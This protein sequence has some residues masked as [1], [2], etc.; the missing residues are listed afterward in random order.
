MVSLDLATLFFV[1][2]IFRSL[3]KNRC[4]SIVRSNSSMEK[5]TET[6]KLRKIYTM[7]Y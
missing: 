4:V 7:K 5:Q 3:K 1:N 6:A 2:F